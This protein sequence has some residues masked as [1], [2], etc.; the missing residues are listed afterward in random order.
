MTHRAHFLLLAVLLL[1]TGGVGCTAVQRISDAPSGD[2]GALRLDVQPSDARIYVD[3]QYRGRVD[4]WSAQT[5]MLHPGMRRVELRADGYI[6]RRFD[7]EVRAGKQG[8]LTVSMEPT[9]ERLDGVAPDTPET[10]D[11]PF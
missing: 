7:I 8:V 2:S 5:V 1:M 4:G 10:T 6:T 3:T 11:L 9:L